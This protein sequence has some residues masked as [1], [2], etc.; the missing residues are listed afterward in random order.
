M[1]LQVLA[2]A[3]R[4]SGLDEAQIDRALEAI[5]APPLMMIG[6]VR[7]DAALAA[8]LTQEPSGV[9]NVAPAMQVV[10]GPSYSNLLR[11]VVR[12]RALI[13]EQEWSG[14]GPDQVP[15]CP[16]CEELTT[17]PHHATCSAFTPAGEVR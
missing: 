8:R 12:L 11:D 10:A 3:L 16:W 7:I 2:D 4:E 1:K 6:P 17:R 15:E 5:D 14:G 9:I 13:K